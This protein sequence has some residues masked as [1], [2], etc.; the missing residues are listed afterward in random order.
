[1]IRLRHQASEFQKIQ[2]DSMIMMLC[3]V[4]RTRDVSET[5]GDWMGG[6]Y[7][8]NPKQSAELISLTTLAAADLEIGRMRTTYK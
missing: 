3:H 5:F 8:S 1:M 2:T 7:P 6:G 4:T